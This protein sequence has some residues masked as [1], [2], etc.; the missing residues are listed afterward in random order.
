MN[1]SAFKH[2]TSDIKRESSPSTDKHIRRK[3]EEEAYRKKRL[4]QLYEEER[5]R[6]ILKEQADLEARK[7]SDFFTPSQKS[8]IPADRFEDVS[9]GYNVPPERR[10]GFQIQGKAKA[11]YN[12]TAQNPRELPFRKGD[13]I[14]LLRKIDKN[15]FEGERNGRV[16]IFPVNYVEVITSIEAAH[17]A[18]QQAEGQARAKYNFNAQTTV[19]LSLRKGDIVTLLRQVDPN[20]FEGRVGNRQGIFP[21]NYVEVLREP[22]TPLITPAPSVITTPMT[23]TPEMLS[24]VS[25]EAPTPP[26][27]PSPG[28][29]SPKSPSSSYSY[30]GGG[31]QMGAQLAPHSQMNQYSPQ[32]DSLNR[33]DSGPRRID[34]GHAPQLNGDYIQ[35]Y[36]SKSLQQSPSSNRKLVSSPGGGG[37]YNSS[38]LYTS[39]GSANYLNSDDF[40]IQSKVPDDDLA[41][42]RYKAIYAYRPQNDDELE[43]LEG[44]EIY[45]MEKCDDGW[46]VGT[47]GRTGMFG[48]FPGNYVIQ[49][50]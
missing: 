30:S 24:P 44:D 17:A 28:A 46:Y 5:R 18:A 34:N 9:V 40:K 45:V 13:L 41:L 36:S 31:R 12:F 27:Q 50:Q 10:R 48:T 15:W 8:P 43:L 33:Y 37:S 6:K 2:Q 20:W 4:E 3:E 32:F 16:G 1:F 42:T 25:M 11:M 49:V 29:F 23:G 39:S 19:E 7:H 38:N 14:Y 47:S 35:Q 21:L 26:P 22:S